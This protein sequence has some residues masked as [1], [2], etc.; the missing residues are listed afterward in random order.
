ML[1]A[2]WYDWAF[3]IVFVPCFVV[4]VTYLNRLAKRVR[5]P[6]EPGPRR[7]RPF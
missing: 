1:A 3:F 2:Q 6:R 7:P 4:G 5:G